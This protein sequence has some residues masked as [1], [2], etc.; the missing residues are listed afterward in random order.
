MMGGIRRL[1]GKEGTLGDMNLS[2][3]LKLMIAGT[4]IYTV[5]AVVFTTE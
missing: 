1:K 2:G 5:L 4:D 3:D